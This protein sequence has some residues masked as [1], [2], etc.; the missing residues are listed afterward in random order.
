MRLQNYE[1]AAD[2]LE[3]ATSIRFAPSV[4]PESHQRTASSDIR[5]PKILSQATSGLTDDD[6]RLTVSEELAGAI[7]SGWKPPPPARKI[8]ATSIEATSIEATSI[9]TTRI[10]NQQ[11]I[12]QVDTAERPNS[13]RSAASY[14]SASDRGTSPNHPPPPPPRKE[15]RNPDANECQP[16]GRRRSSLLLGSMSSHDISQAVIPNDDYGRPPPPVP[17]DE[18]LVQQPTTASAERPSP[19]PP[20][21]SKV[22]KPAPPPPRVIAVAMGSPQPPRPP[23]LAFHKNRTDSDDSASPPPPPRPPL[24]SDASDNSAPPPPAIPPKAQ[25]QV[26]SG[27]PPAIGELPLP[28]RRTTLQPQQVA[29]LTRPGIPPVMGVPVGVFPSANG[30][31]IVIPTNLDAP[32]SPVNTTSHAPPPLPD[33]IELLDERSSSSAPPPDPYLLFAQYKE[34]LKDSGMKPFVKANFVKPK[35]GMFSKKESDSSLISFNAKPQK[36][37]GEEKK[38]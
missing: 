13:D 36:V 26:R 28:P 27:P 21:V 10:K 3:S 24:L 31:V 12:L 23:P 34:R 9:E 8:T 14:G 33:D 17:S 35:G 16:V 37:R 30:E 25:Q 15:N 38:G 32:P 20:G 11:Q 1:A 22:G 2:Q 6:G 29:T 5:N 18:D 4:H 7:E 19:P